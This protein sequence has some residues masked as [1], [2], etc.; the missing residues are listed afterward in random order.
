M[1]AGYIRIKK[2]IYFEPEDKKQLI[3][4]RN[5]HYKDDLQVD[6]I[7]IGYGLS[8]GLIKII[9]NQ[10]CKAEITENTCTII[11]LLWK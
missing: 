9:N 8:K 3:E 1:K 7:E 11:E 4:I 10:P 5:N 2:K 6:F